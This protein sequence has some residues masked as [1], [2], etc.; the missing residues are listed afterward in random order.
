M[1]EQLAIALKPFP[2][3]KICCGAGEAT[4]LPD[5]CV[6][7]IVCSQSLGWLDFDGFR[8]ECR[9]IVKPGAIIASI[10]NETPGEVHTIRS[11]HYTS[12]QASELFFHNP[13]IREFSNN[14]QYSYKKWLHRIASNS[15]YPLPSD[16]GYDEQIAKANEFFNQNSIG[17]FICEELM[18]VV[19]SEK[20][21]YT[22]IKSE[23]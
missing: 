13:V 1:R 21:F 23:H 5:Q 15:D 6:D 3:A 8:T 19:Y 16:P 2:N 20:V 9:R 14:I 12:R 22:L 17:G 18:T 10:F 7:A 11:H 4:T